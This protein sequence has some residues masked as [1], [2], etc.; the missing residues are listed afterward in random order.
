MLCIYSAFTHSILVSCNFYAV[1][2]VPIHFKLPISVRLHTA[3]LAP[4]NTVVSSLNYVLLIKLYFTYILTLLLASLCYTISNKCYQLPKSHRSFFLCILPK[5]RMAFKPL[6][7]SN[8]PTLCHE[9]RFVVKQMLDHVI[10][11]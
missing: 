9:N 3:F 10:E 6:T 1:F 7:L 2:T 8:H 11:G 5:Y 4:G